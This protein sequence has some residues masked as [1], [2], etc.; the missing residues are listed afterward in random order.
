MDTNSTIQYAVQTSV[1]QQPAFIW[2]LVAILAI[3]LILVI[4]VGIFTSP[5]TKD[6]RKVGRR[7][8]QNGNF[9]IIWFTI[10]ITEAVL[11]LFLIVFP[12]YLKL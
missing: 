8:I 9:W 1:T 7:T 4:L 6:G 11:M 10:L 2:S 3:P 5:K 12:I